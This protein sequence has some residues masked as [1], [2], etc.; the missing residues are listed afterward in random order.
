MSAA[1]MSSRSALRCPYTAKGMTAEADAATQQAEKLK[2][3]G[4]Q[5]KPAGQQDKIRL[6]T[7]D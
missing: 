2:A 3:K 1:T 7:G 6:T 4:D 5:E